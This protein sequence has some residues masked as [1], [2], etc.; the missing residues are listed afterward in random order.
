MCR[1]WGLNFPEVDNNNEIPTY[2]AKMNGFG[3][4]PMMSLAF[5]AS[6]GF[7]APGSNY[8][9]RGRGRGRGRFCCSLRWPISKTD[10]FFTDERRG[11]GRGR[12]GHG[13]GRAPAPETSDNRLR[14]MVI[15]L[16][17]DEVCSWSVTRWTETGVDCV[18]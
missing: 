1:H 15:K 4:M 11:G 17:D 9:G 12:G 16:G 8:G 5:P 13:G 7:G 10:C 18:C 2:L 6:P 3:Q 14:K